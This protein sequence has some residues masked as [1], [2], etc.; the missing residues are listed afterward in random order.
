MCN[1]IIETQLTREI[2]EAGVKEL[3]LSYHSKSHALE[4]HCGLSHMDLKNRIRKIPYQEDDITVM[5]RFTE[6]ESGI[7]SLI[8]SCLESNFKGI[9]FWLE[10]GNGNALE[11]VKPFHHPVGD[12][13]VKGT[14]WNVLHPMSSVRVMI[15]PSDIRGRLF[16]VITAYPVPD[17]DECDEIWDSID[18]WSQ[19]QKDKRKISSSTTKKADN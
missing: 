19:I 15:A 5:S 4:R 8:Q 9:R 10:S 11:L 14:D 17:M 12:G 2:K 7:V 1:Q 6:D 13:I 18:E 16:K 3:F